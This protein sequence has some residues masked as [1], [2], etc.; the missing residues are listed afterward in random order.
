VPASKDQHKSSKIKTIVNIITILALIGFVYALRKQIGATLTNLQSANLLALTLMPLL[1]V[2]NYHSY[3]KMYSHLFHIMR[4]DVP[5]KKLIKVQLELNF[6]NNVF[7]SG[8]VS[9]ISYFGLRMRKHGIGAGKSTLV[10]VMKFALLFISFQ[11]LLGIGLIILAIGGKASNLL[12]LIAGSLATLLL[13][14][15]MLLAY[16]VGSRERIHSF[17]AFITNG[18]N[19]LIHIVRRKHPETINTRKVRDLFDELH[20]NYML[21][22]ND[23]KLLKKPLTY[24][25]LANISEVLTVYAVYMA[26]DNFVNIGAVI[27]AY[28]IANFAGLISVLPGGVGIYEALMTGTLAASG[29]SAAVSIPVTVM[30]RVL[31][32]SLQLPFGYYFYHKNLQARQNEEDANE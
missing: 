2:V 27:I 11:I 18:L 6:V 22:K 5:Y 7:P 4:E 8:G 25:L 30:Y 31:N 20:D 29:V 12:V 10:Q 3:A 13:V 9:G 23:L 28:A 15:T 24:G 19:R 26:L 32:M 16:I 21:I 14:G 17:F 1:Q